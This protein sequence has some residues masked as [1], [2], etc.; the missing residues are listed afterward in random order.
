[1]PGPEVCMVLGGLLLRGVPGPGE[2]APGG[3]APGE[4]GIPGCTEADHP[5]WERQLLLRTVRIL[6]ECILVSI[7]FLLPLRDAPK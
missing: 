6:L 2:S 7:C 5:P 1:M 4:G 3:S